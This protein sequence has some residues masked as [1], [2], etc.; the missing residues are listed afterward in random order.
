MRAFE[1]YEWTPARGGHSGVPTF[2]LTASD[3]RPLYAKRLPRAAAEGSLLLAEAE[4]IVWLRKAG[5]PG[6]ELVDVGVSDEWQWLV[7]TEVPGRS[8]AE[9]WPA[10][11][12]SAVIDA[13]ADM[14][15]MLHASPV[16]ECPFRADLADL[17]SRPGVEELKPSWPTTEDL[18]VSHGDYCLPNMLLDPDTL[19]P[20]GFIDL[21]DLG[22]ADRYRD[23]AACGM[24]I[25]SDELNPQYDDAQV[26]RFF[27]RY[28]ADPTDP[29][30]D[31]YLRAYQLL[32]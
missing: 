13:I 24:S 18:V 15:R 11:R 1:M 7:M 23:L 29:R 27:A 25:G 3:R 28:G 5:L 10:D 30:R 12:R 17:A 32:P 22:V 20:T 16:A 9:P 4:R 6:P 14:L 26:A 21:G 2:R 19:E 8:G 31:F